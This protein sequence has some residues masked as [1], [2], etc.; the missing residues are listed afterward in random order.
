[1]DSTFLGQGSYGC[2]YKKKLKSINHSLPHTDNGSNGDSLSKIYASSFFA[3]RE[4]E[5]GKQIIKIP[6]YERYFSPVLENCNA[7]LEELDKEDIDKCNLITNNQDSKNN[8]DIY[9]TTTTKWIKGQTLQTYLKEY[10]LTNQSSP[11]T[12][13][14]KIFYIYTC[15]INSIKILIEHNVIHFDLSERNII[16]DETDRPIIIDFGMSI[17]KSNIK[18]IE[19]FK[20]EFG[21]YSFLKYK[22]LIT[23]RD[24]LKKE[25]KT[26]I[27]EPWC[28][29]IIML[30]YLNQLDSPNIFESSPEKHIK[31]MKSLSDEYID[32][33]K[34]EKINF[35]QDEIAK[36]KKSK[37]SLY[38]SL[39]NKTTLEASKEILKTSTNWDIYAITFICLKHLTQ[40]QAQA[41]SQ[42]QAQTQTQA[43]AQ[44]QTTQMI[45]KMKSNIMQ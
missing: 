44:A 30:L 31:E 33:L 9:F 43:Q 25:K 29:E 41:Q 3:T 20:Y 15:L 39:S 36:Y 26:D 32:L 12:I 28:V 17:K 34:L 21:H 37:Y 24:S 45:E 19:N 8:K 1:M 23:T 7:S 42:A 22:T 5:I 35:T 4:I 2:I 11:H 38:E 14:N 6:N 10:K 18:T 13:D 40:A 27:Y 16:M